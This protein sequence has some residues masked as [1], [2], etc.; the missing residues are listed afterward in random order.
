VKAAMGWLK[1]NYTVDANPGMPPQ[2]AARGLYYYYHT[3]SKSLAV[4]GDDTFV[5]DKGTQH[6]WRTDLFRAIEKRQEADGSWVNKN[7]RWMEGDPNLVTG[8]VLMALS[9]CKPR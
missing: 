7:D 4:L 2:L 1:K 8:Y 3:M 6:D 5:D 9:H